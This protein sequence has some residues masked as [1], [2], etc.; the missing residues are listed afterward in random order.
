MF[1]L[2]G[3]A[4]K[5]KNKRVKRIT[6]FCLRKPGIRNNKSKTIMQKIQ[7]KYVKNKYDSK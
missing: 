3:Y 6:T 1:F 7:D 4:A 2:Q 5:Y